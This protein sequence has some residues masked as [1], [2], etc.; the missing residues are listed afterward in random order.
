[1]TQMIASSTPAGTLPETV[2]SISE[3]AV[4]TFGPSG[5]DLRVLAR[6]NE[7]MA[8]AVRAATAEK[9]F[10]DIAEEAADALI[11]LCRFAVRINFGGLTFDEFLGPVTTP[12]RMRV[13]DAAILAQLRMAKLLYAAQFGGA[14]REVLPQLWREL[15]ELINACGVEVQTVVDAKMTRNRQRVWKCDGTGHGYHVRDK[16][17]TP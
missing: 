13:L 8:E 1:M 15:K 7:E 5:S 9:P 11:V 3:W 14:V 10:A 4:A 16:A 12:F 17:A 6:V 2:S